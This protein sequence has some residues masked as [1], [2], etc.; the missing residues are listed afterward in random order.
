MALLDRDL[1]DYPDAAASHTDV[2]AKDPIEID[3]D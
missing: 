3:N 2:K 1:I